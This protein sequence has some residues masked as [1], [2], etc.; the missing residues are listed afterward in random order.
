V[1][2]Y[3]HALATGL[4]DRREIAATISDARRLLE[5]FQAH[6][7]YAEMNAAERFHEVPYT[8]RGAG[9]DEIGVVDV[10]YRVG[11]RWRVV[12]FKTDEIRDAARLDAKVAEYRAQIA[13]YA[14]AVSALVGTMPETRL[15]FLDVHGEVRVALGD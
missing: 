12:D 1:F 15:C 3:P 5:R 14:A 2:L 9:G 6:A 10:L 13:R 4:T 7:L 11:E 8:Y